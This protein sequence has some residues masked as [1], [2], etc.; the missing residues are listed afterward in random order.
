MP[1][2]RLLGRHHY[3]N[4]NP[5][6]TMKDARETTRQTFQ[7]LFDT[8]LVEQ[9]ELLVALEQYVEMLHNIIDERYD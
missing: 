8:A 5:M 7:F 3:T 9:H 6:D 2:I 4:H 1:R